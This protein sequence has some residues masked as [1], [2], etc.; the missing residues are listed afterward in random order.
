VCLALA[1]GAVSGCASTASGPP[2]GTS[3]TERQFDK[4]FLVLRDLENGRRTNGEWVEEVVA[5]LPST[6]KIEK[7]NSALYTSALR[8]HGMTTEGFD[9]MTEQVNIAWLSWFFE[10]AVEE[11]KGDAQAQIRFYHAYITRDEKKLHLYRT[12]KKEGRHTLTLT[13]RRTIVSLIAADKRDAH[14]EVLKHHGY[15]VRIAEHDLAKSKANVELDPTE[16][17]ADGRLL[18]ARLKE[19]ECSAKLAADTELIANP[20]LGIG[21]ADSSKAI[22]DIDHQIKALTDEIEELKTKIRKIENPE[23]QFRKAREGIT[24]TV[25]R[26]PANNM[27]IFRKHAREF[28]DVVGAEKQPRLHFPLGG[29]NRLDSDFGLVDTSSPGTNEPPASKSATADASTLRVPTQ[30]EVDALLKAVAQT[31][32]QVDDYSK[33][34]DRV[35]RTLLTTLTQNSKTLTTKVSL[36]LFAEFHQLEKASDDLGILRDQLHDAATDS[37]DAAIQNFEAYQRLIRETKRQYELCKDA[38]ERL[39]ADMSAAANS[40]R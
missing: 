10:Q 28:Q 37:P 5:G 22:D 23:A 17:G 31:E 35:P 9:Q 38:R 36:Q 26:V 7:A 24:Q 13:E 27:A 15:D 20:D 19:A 3:F 14:Q 40:G 25:A 16:R 18:D 11:G 8:A 39:F 33:E 30:A 1:L 6:A 29:P 2:I 21:D 32:E 34:R 12:A 4:Y